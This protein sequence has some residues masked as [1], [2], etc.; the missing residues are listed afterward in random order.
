MKPKIIGITGGIGS[1]K[2][3]VSEIIK[4]RGYPVYYSDARAKELMNESEE[5]KR[6]LIKTFGENIVDYSGNLLYNKIAE[7]VFDDVKALRA[8][9]ALVHPYVFKDFEKWLSRQT[10]KWVFKEAAILFESG[11]FKQ[12]DAVILVTAP[13]SLR[14]K[15]VQERSGFTEDDIRQRM[16]MQWKDER[17]K[18]LTDYVIE[19]DSTIAE[20][21]KKVDSILEDLRYRYED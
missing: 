3:T 8:L 11:S 5:L 17:K 16:R 21:E 1:G 10:T 12:C 6:E 2:T 14:I 18:E 15:R 9:E 19:N 20:L 7:L 4:K 13:E